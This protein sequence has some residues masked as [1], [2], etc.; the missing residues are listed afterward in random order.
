MKGFT[1]HKRTKHGKS[2]IGMGH[3][4]RGN[5]EDCLFA[6]RGKPK[7]VN[8]GVRQFIEAPR[9]KHS[10]K[11]PEARERLVLLMGDVPRIELF[12]REAVPGWDV[13]GLEVESTI[14]IKMR[15]CHMNEMTRGEREELQRLVRQREKV[16]KSAAKQRSKELLADFESQISAEYSFDDDA[17][18]AAAAK[19]A[20][21]EVQKARG[22][23][24]AR[25]QEL[26][27]PKQ[28]APSLHL[29]WSHRGYGNALASR[30]DELRRSA[31]AQIASMEQAA[32]VKIE[33]GSVDLLT[34]IAAA[35]LTS[36][37]ARGFLSAL[38]SVESLMPKLS[39]RE[40]AA[41]SDPPIVEQLITP[42]ALRQRRWVRLF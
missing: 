31:Q 1:W 4:T 13:W 2:H 23:V 34:Q 20:E 19:A 41:E 6:V 32:I 30:R 12:A 10:E 8:H 21:G 29:S 14:E 3:W 42:N 39:Y 33:L 15:L 11:P 37:A 36:E 27:I 28:F 17:V 40:V 38:P 22:R 35:G 24:A 26:G 16:Q 9:G 7:P 5:T 18:W 25:C